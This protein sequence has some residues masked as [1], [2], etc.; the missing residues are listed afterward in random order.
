MPSTENR[1]DDI[2]LIDINQAQ[3]F[4]IHDAGNN[5]QNRHVSKQ[6]VIYVVV[7][8]LTYVCY[9][10][11]LVFIM[12]KEMNKEKMYL[13]EYII[14]GISIGFMVVIIGSIIIKLVIHTDNLDR[15]LYLIGLLTH[16]IAQFAVVICF[17]YVY[18]NQY[19]LMSYL[20]VVL[21]ALDINCCLIFKKK[22][23]DG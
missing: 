10:S 15:D 13:K 2:P 11:I 21:V 1:I 17:I 22:Y 14:V 7:Y 6:F 20:S 5:I 19:P 18:H 4:P 12:Y 23:N 16:Y 3:N 8:F 9:Y